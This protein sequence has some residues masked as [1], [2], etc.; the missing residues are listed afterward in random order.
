MRLLIHHVLDWAPKELLL[1]D[2]E[3]LVNGLL[4]T[5]NGFLVEHA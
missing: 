2:E 4:S 3:E 5:L 1:K